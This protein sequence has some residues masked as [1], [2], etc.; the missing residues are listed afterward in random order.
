MSNITTNAKLQEWVTSLN[1]YS[2]ELAELV[3]IM[4]DEN[5]DLIQYVF[6]PTFINRN[7]A[8]AGRVI[9]IKR[10]KSVIHLLEELRDDL[11]A[12]VIML[13]DEDNRNVSAITRCASFVNINITYDMLTPLAAETLNSY[14]EAR[15]TVSELQ[16]AELVASVLGLPIEPDDA[17]NQAPMSEV[18]PLDLLTLDVGEE[19]KVTNPNTE[20]FNK[21]TDIHRAV[22]FNFE[23]HD[24][25]FGGYD[26]TDMASLMDRGYLIGR[27]LNDFLGSVIDKENTLP[28]GITLLELITINN[29]LAFIAD[30]EASGSPIHSFGLYVWN[31]NKYLPDVVEGAVGLLQHMVNRL[32]LAAGKLHSRRGI[33][34]G[35]ST[36]FGLGLDAGLDARGSRSGRGRAVVGRGLRD[37]EEDRRDRE[38]E[39][40]R[41]RKEEMDRYYRDHG[42]RGRYSR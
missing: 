6:P 13:Q 21:V 41:D 32:K 18:P 24:K 12:L 5:H 4:S 10:R 37:L 19:V 36:L 30:L 22:N 26:D 8:A 34:E 9:R 42:R 25:Y 38:E 1:K 7:F 11:T 16:D 39:D 29:N 3:S 28:N 27:Q 20:Y 40:P 31:V 17:V 33:T 23:Q 14:G 15:Q 35:L 2:N